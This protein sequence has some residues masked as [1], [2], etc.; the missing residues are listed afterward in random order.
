MTTVAGFSIAGYALTEKIYEDSKTV[1]Y[2]G[3]RN[4]D[5]QPIVFKTLQSDHPTPSEIARIRHEFEITKNLDLPGMV[6]LYEIIEYNGLSLILED[7][8]GRSL[9]TF[10]SGDR[11]DLEAFLQIGIQLTES[12]GELHQLNI[13]HK[14]IKPLNIIFNAST[15]QIKLTD[16]SIASRLSRENQLAYNPNQIEGTLAYLSPEQTGR[17]NRAIDYR[18]DFYSLGVT[19]Y[20]LLTGQLPFTAVDPMEMIHCHIARQPILPHQIRL[21]IPP[22]LSQIV[23]KL[24]A[25]MAEDRYQNAYGI[26][27]DLERCLQ[28]WRTC[29]KIE[30]FELGQQDI[31]TRFQIPQKLYGRQAEIEILTI[32]FERVTCGLAEL[33][34]IAGY[35]GVGKSALVHEIQK[36]VVQQ[37]GY[38]I[39][40]KF[41]QFK[42]NAPYA[43]LIQ[44]FQELIRQILTES[45]GQIQGWKQKI[46]KAVGSNGQIIIDVIPEVELII[47]LQAAV[48]QLE[49]SESQNRFNLVFQQFL[50]VFAQKEHLLVLFLDDLQWA[51]SASLK[52]MQSLIT[53]SDRPCLLLIGAYRDNEVSPTHALMVTLESIRKEAEVSQITLLPLALDSVN[54]LLAD[55]L[56]R[57]AEQCQ[58]LAELLLNETDGNPFFLNLLLTTLYEEALLSY[59]LSAR[60]WQWD[61]E[62]IQTVGMTDNVV[63]LMVGKLQK[64]PPVTQNAL[65]LAAC[66]GNTFSLSLLA[67]ANEKSLSATAH[68]LWNAL[69]EGLILPL[70]QSYKLAH[71]DRLEASLSQN[72]DEPAYRFLHDRVQQAA[73]LL[74]PA[75]DKQATHLKVG[76]L[77]LKHTQPADR[78]EKIFELVN[79][80]NRGVDLL[81]CDRTTDRQE[82]SAECIQLA[83]LNLIAGRKA[84]A[85]AAYE[86]ASQ[87]LTTGLNLL[88]ADSWAKH[89]ELALA[90]YTEAA[91]VEYFTAHFEQAEILSEVVLRHAHDLQQKVRVYETRIYFYIAQNQMLAAIETSLHVLELLGIPLAQEPPPAFVIEDLIHLPEMADLDKLAAMRIVITLVTPCLNAKPELLGAI[92]YT[93]VNLSIQ[94]GNSAYSAFGYAFYGLVLC[95]NSAS[96]DTGYRF[97][98]LGLKLLERFQAKKLQAKV[99]NIFDVFVRHWKEPVRNTIAPLRDAIQVGLETGDVEYACYNATSYCNYLFF[100]GEPLQEVNQQQQQYI[101]FLLKFKQEYQIYFGQICRQLVL[102]LM[103]QAKDPKTLVGECFDE[104]EVVPLLINTQNGTLLFLYHLSKTILLF[105]YRD[106]P[107]ATVHAREAAKY[108]GNMVGFLQFAE[109]NF[110]YS[111]SLLAAC[112]NADET[113][114]QA[115]LETVAENQILMQQWAFHAPANHQHKYD[116]VEAERAKWLGRD[117]DAMTYYDTAIQSAKD[118]GYVQEEALAYERAAAFYDSRNRDRI[119]QLYLKEAYYAYLRWGAMG[120]VG[121]MEARYPQF[122]SQVSADIATAGQS[123]TTTSSI[124]RSVRDFDLGTIVK[125]SQAIAGEIILE[126]L[127]EQLLKIVMENAGAQTSCL[128]LEKNGQLMIEATA[129]LD[130]EQVQMWQSVPVAVSQQIPVSIV[131]YAARTQ[132]NVVLNDA[133]RQ[134]KFTRDPYVVRTEP[135]SLLCTPILNQGKLIGLLYLENNLTTEAF[136]PQRLEVLSLLSSQVAISLENAR[137]YANLADA[138]QDLRQAN[139]QLEDYSRTLQQKVEERTLELKEKNTCLKAQATQLKQTVEELKQ[140]Q[141]QLIQT[142]KMSGLGQ[143]VAGVAHEINN[144]V[145]FIHGNL[146]HAQNYGNELLELIQL[147]QNHYPQPALEIQAKVEAIDLGY[148]QKDLPKLLGSMKLGADR[149]RQIVLSLRNFSRLD[150]ADM[151]PVD[152]HEG[153]DSTLLILQNRLKGKTAN[154]GIQIVKDYGDLPEIECYAGQLNQ[155]F[156]NL[157]N[158]AIDALEDCDRSCLLAETRENPNLISIHTEV[159]D[160]NWV[161]IRFADNG[162]GVPEEIRHRLFDPFFTT[163]PVGSGTGLGLSISYQIVVDKHRGNLKCLSTLGEGTEFVIEIPVR[164]EAA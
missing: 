157:L 4:R 142:E 61:L 73:Y 23:M 100:V 5:S 74:I 145:N 84:K 63:E 85:A 35:S 120:K 56:H 43:S 139:I 31:S 24:L 8:G 75:E 107:Q 99:V 117:L 144:P 26:K 87:Y 121:E 133:A 106:Y 162:S 18:T 164:H 128:M 149:I 10:L 20:E 19:F 29:G 37:H 109:H 67:I 131:S 52:L 156:M 108:R 1:V 60:C 138:T 9:K 54:Q 76:R 94:S 130:H 86:L 97:G 152:I 33:M 119:A 28:Q 151:K 140:T 39:T 68:E 80:L 135:K 14:D 114:R 101:E 79:Q 47:G 42:R 41:D 12:L 25:K 136:T 90:L 22:I 150:Q 132:E 15:N 159:I 30:S 104:Q 27:A 163:K 102:N 66:I 48:P 160:P 45:E 122:L 154:L 36:S 116:L 143:L 112:A 34:L 77:L 153:I 91:E 50:G 127:L 123:T 146:L 13:I 96:I 129:A 7:F 81:L 83:G 62:R 134:G 32:A 65:K 51:D 58:P 6:K 113:E 71:M 125:A 147:Y 17:M 16:F 59:D 38:F 70:S 46:L 64:L 148:L 111:L 53:S 161:R 55:T 44:A 155:V 88:A 82:N 89:H 124:S 95:S 78:E 158:N 49:A 110:Y 11:F 103:G 40:G 141:L 3:L 21:D 72:Q 126:R 137:L 92:A 105:V 2:R 118:N 115:A 69:Q 57:P 93:L 98:Q